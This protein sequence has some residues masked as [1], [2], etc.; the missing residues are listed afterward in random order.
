MVEV[1]ARHGKGKNEGLEK[2]SFSKLRYK[3]NWT[4]KVCS[5]VQKNWTNKVCSGYKVNWTNKVCSEQTKFV[6]DT[7]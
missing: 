6:L 5:K 4:N 3:V 7:K 1:P 2:Q